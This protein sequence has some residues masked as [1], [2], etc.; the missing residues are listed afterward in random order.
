MQRRAI[1]TG[2]A[3]GIGLGITEHLLSR[4]WRV[5][6]IDCDKEALARL[7]HRET[8]LPVPADISCEEDVKAAHDR[9][10][11]WTDAI[12]LLVNNAGIADPETGPLDTLTLKTWNRMLA[13]NLTG[14]FLMV[15]ATLPM[16]RRAAEDAPGAASVINIASTRALQSEPHTEAYAA[17]KG[18]LL[19]L[20][21]ALAMSL[22]P[23]LRV[24]AVLPGWIAAPGTELG[25]TDHSQHPVGR[26]GRPADIAG[27]VE[28][29]AGEEAG[30]VTGQTLTV[31]G[32]MTVKMIYED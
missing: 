23:Q 3:S 5:A 7:P 14:A 15:R 19:S 13:T 12:H 30:F 6:A 20:T 10:S 11:G 2:A 8:L 21:H 29:L 27:A 22:G 16:L 32:G 28:Y 1:V 4:G 26:V 18:G 25:D 31:D 24:N 17:T 9:I